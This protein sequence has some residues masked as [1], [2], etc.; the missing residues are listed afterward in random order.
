[1][2]F[3]NDNLLTQQFSNETYEE[4][5]SSDVLD[6][7][8]SI[9]D[10]YNHSNA[11][12]E[13]LTS[14]LSS[15]IDPS[16]GN[17]ISA[18]IFGSY[19]RL[20]ASTVS[21]LDHLI[22]V[23]NNDIDQ[24]QLREA[25]LETLAELDIPMPNPEGVFNGEV[26]TESLI[27]NVGSFSDD[28]RTMSQRLLF[29]LESR[30]IF[31]K[32]L[33]EELIEDLLCFYGK[34]VVT[35]PRKNYVFL[36]N[37]L[38]RYFRTICVNYAY[39]KSTDEKKWPLRNI[40]L[41]H[42]RVVMYASLIAMLGVLSTYRGADINDRLKEFIVLT[43][44]QRLH[45]AYLEAGDTGFYKIAGYYD[46]FLSHL[47]SGKTR[48]ALTEISYDDRYSHTEFIVLKTNSDA[49]SAELSRF[50]LDRRGSWSDRFF[51]YLLM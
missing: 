51:E 26:V 12:T 2:E 29:L 22:V 42:S 17:D 13:K 15:K 18:V 43:P 14:G 4:A 27:E 37:D 9:K 19:A 8:S 31:G 6:R 5:F 28:Y 23:R 36:L 25:L 49:L 39:T 11:V 7:Y 48:K 38:I 16:K 20:D 45:R 44:L 10:N 21:D 47:N 33:Y 3:I 1:M 35:D 40:K 41:R 24:S 32:D 34:D 30:Q 46:V 50:F